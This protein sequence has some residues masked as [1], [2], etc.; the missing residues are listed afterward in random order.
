MKMR[1]ALIAIAGLL[2]ALAV[3]AYGLGWGLIS[4][5]VTAVL[6]LLILPV[7][8]AAAVYC[9]FF[10]HYPVVKSLIERLDRLW[11][12]WVLKL[13]WFNLLL[14]AGWFL[15]R[16]V[17]FQVLPVQSLATVVVYILGNA[18]F[19][20]YDICFTGLIRG[21]GQIIKKIR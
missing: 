12:E 11:L 7:K 16:I 9:L 13:L 3:M 14:T 17:L 4:F 21:A 2:P 5:A 10:G 18:A 20:I 1:L 8:D 19:I 6:A 15:L